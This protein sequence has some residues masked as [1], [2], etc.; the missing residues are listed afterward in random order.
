L[1]LLGIAR[2]QLRDQR[3]GKDADHRDDN[4]EFDKCKTVPVA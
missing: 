3:A 2:F 4:Q 1:Q